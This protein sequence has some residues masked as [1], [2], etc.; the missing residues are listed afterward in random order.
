LTPVPLT[1]EEYRL[2]S[3]WLTTEFGLWFGPERREILRSRLEPRRAELGFDSFHQLFFFLK[4]HPERQAERQRLIPYLTNN[5]SYFFRER[6]QLEVFRD[7]LLPALRARLAEEGRTE[8]RILSAG[9]SAGQEP[10]SLALLLREARGSL[11]SLQPRITGVDLDP[12]ILEQARAGRYT[13]HSFRGVDDEVRDRHFRQDGEFDWELLSTVREMVEFR[14][15]NLADP[16]WADGLPPQDV[17]FCRNVLIYFDAEGLRRAARGLHQSLATGGYLFL[18]HAES[19]HRVP[20]PFAPER[21]P[22]AVF[23]RKVER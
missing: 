12:K 6:K 2:F 4:F 14:Q 18:G 16:A 22:G 17:V 15:A 5:E 11:G 23:Y 3:E 7:T 19:L 13:A 20:T 21:H 8:L 1:D 9:C 10:Y